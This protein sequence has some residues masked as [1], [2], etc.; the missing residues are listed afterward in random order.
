MKRFWKHTGLALLYL[1]LFLLV[2]MWAG[3]MFAIGGVFSALLDSAGR[4]TPFLYDSVMVHFAD[5]MDVVM[6]LCYVATFGVLYALLIAQQGTR[7]VLPAMGLRRPR[8]PEMLWAPMLLGLAAFFAVSA[9]MSLIP[10][11]TPVMQEYIEAASSLSYGRY[12]WADIL[13]TVIGA[14]LVEEI[15]FRGLIYGNLKKAMP[16]WVALL[17]QALLFGFVHGQLLWSAF[18]F[19]LGL[20][21]GL[22]ADYFDSIWPAVL[23]HLCF[24]A[25]NY[26]PLFLE[27]DGTGTVVLFLASLLVVAT[28][29]LVL[30]L[31]RRQNELT[32]PAN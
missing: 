13:A 16:V 27:L 29:F 28:V 3:G 17:V 30:V 1:A 7:G 9:G 11:E 22:T 4:L 25:G 6:L 18:T 23:L 14:P 32:R 15:V 26:L 21:L 10:P 24:N 12:P 8:S 5:M 19:L 2:Q 20:A 31:Y